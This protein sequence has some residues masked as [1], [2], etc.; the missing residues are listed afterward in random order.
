MLLSRAKRFQ[1]ALS[2]NGN[3]IR[4]KAGTES[5][6]HGQNEDKKD[7]SEEFGSA[8]FPRMGA[9]ERFPQTRSSCDVGNLES[10]YNRAKKVKEG[11]RPHKPAAVLNSL[12]SSNTLLLSVVLP[13]S[14]NGKT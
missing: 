11:K 14:E 4:M 6:G 2:F 10:L 7:L 1:H 12:T 13:A 9:V 5:K 3:S 8:F